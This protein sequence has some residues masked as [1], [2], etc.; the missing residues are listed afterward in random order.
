LD[1]YIIIKTLLDS[2]LQQLTVIKT[3][4]IY[5]LYMRNSWFQSLNLIGWEALQDYRYSTCISTWRDSLHFTPTPFF[6][7]ATV[8]M[9]Q[10]M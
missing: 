9:S 8:G 10:I 3:I 1:I 7:N 2:T 5:I 6:L 4:Y